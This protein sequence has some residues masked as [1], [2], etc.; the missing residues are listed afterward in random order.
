MDVYLKVTDD[1]GK[2]W[3]QRR[4]EGTSTSTTTPS[5][6]TPRTPDHLLDRQ[7]RRDLR[8]LGPLRDVGLQGEPAGDAVLPGRRRR[9]PPV[10]QRLRRHAGQLHAR[11][12]LADRQR[13][14]HPRTRTGSSPSGG[15]G[16]V[17]AVD[18]KDPNIVYSESQH[19]GLVA[20]RPED[21]RAGR[22]PAAARAGRGAAPLELGLAAAHPPP[23]A[24]APLLRGAEASSGATTAGDSWNAVSP[25]LTRQVDRNRL[26]VM[27]RV[28]RRR[29]RRQER[30]DLASTG[31]SSP[32]PR[33]RRRKASLYAGTDDGLVQMTEDGGA[34]WRRSD[35]VPGRPGDDLRGRPRSPRRTRRTSSTPPSTTTS[36]ATSS[37]TLLRSADRGKTWASIAG[38]LPAARDRLHGRRGPERAG[39]P[40]LRARSSDS[41]SPATAGSGGSASKGGLP[42]INVRDLAIQAR[43]DDLV[44]ATFG[45]GFY[46]LDDLTPLRLSTPELAR[47]GGRPLPRPG[48]HGV[49]PP[50]ALRAEGTRRSWASPSSP[51]P[52]RPSAPSSPTT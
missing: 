50:D 10:L 12:P 8:D 44:V 7:R 23:L 35:D 34:S 42:T 38:D 11:R 26:P 41:S 29:R 5:G 24:D 33:A 17:A 43:E 31:T 28:W 1:G 18:P 32:S 22:H 4:R 21:R 2:T 20:V 13:P 40:L 52:T 45:R 47:E 3:T 9:R 46:V 15:D 51:R 49:H 36:G 25:D 27:G 19:G 14:R 39:P 6:S 30:V 48:R 37:P 16:F